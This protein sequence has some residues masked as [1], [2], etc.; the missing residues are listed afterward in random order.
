[1]D[2]REIIVCGLLGMEKKVERR[3]RNGERLHRKASS[4]LAGRYRKKLTGKTDWY[5]EKEKDPE[6]MK[7]LRKEWKERENTRS[8]LG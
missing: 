2:G 8:A 7:L 3:K 5:R 1:M 4:K 6:E